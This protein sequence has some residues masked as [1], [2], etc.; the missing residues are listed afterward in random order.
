MTQSSPT[1]SQTHR[2]DVISHCFHPCCLFFSLSPL[3]FF[4]LLISFY[5]CSLTVSLP[6]EKWPCLEKE[7]LNHV[8][9]HCIYGISPTFI[10]SATFPASIMKW[11]K[12]WKTRTM[13]IC[14]YLTLYVF[15]G[16]CGHWFLQSLEQTLNLPCQFLRI[17]LEVKGVC[18]LWILMEVC[19]GQGD[20]QQDVN[21]GAKKREKAA[22]L[23][24]SPFLSLGVRCWE[25]L[26]MVMT[27]IKH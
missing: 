25:P 11:H 7:P 15:S 27:L 2:E 12:D 5:T 10:I 18:S 1:F 3:F 24:I 17:T 4:S 9:S 8:L 13:K 6:E 14:S 19:L 21:W 23:K 16:N 26:P 20:F 22:C